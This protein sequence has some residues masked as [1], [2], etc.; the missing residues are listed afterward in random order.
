M[1][2]RREPGAAKE[3]DNDEKS[4]RFDMG[5]HHLRSHTD[6]DPVLRREKRPDV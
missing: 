2:R 5:H 1:T 4:A 3:E 6:G